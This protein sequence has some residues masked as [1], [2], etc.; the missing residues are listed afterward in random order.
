V[1]V[2]SAGFSEGMASYISLA[3]DP[4]DSLPYVAFSDDGNNDKAT[5]MKFTGINWVNVGNPGFSAG[6][7]WY[8]SLTFNPPGQPYVAFQDW[9]NSHKATVMKFDGTNWVILGDAGFSTGEAVYTS[10]AISPSDGQPYVAYEDYGNSMKA[11]VMKYD[12]VY[13]GINEPQKLRLS[14]Y[15]NPATDKISIEISVVTEQSILTI[16][17]V[18]GQELIK[19]KITDR[20]TQVDISSLPPGIYFLKITG[21]RMAQV[22]KII[23][24]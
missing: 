7:A 12:S 9:G 17:N 8:T 4:S 1:N 20:K 13:V 14:V 16:V 2:G 3:F 6:S 24:N 18:E 21:E 19:Q 11:T 22:E 15:P 10:L 5:L 23:R